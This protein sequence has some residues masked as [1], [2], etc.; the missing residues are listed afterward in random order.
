MHTYLL[1]CVCF[2]IISG[3][4]ILVNCVNKPAHN[5]YAHMFLFNSIPVKNTQYLKQSNNKLLMK[6]VAEIYKIGWK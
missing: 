4:L 2:N 1:T 5:I 6:T 3:I